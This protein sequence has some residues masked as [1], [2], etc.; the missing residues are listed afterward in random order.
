M[1]FSDYFASVVSNIEITDIIDILLLSIFIYVILKF[2]RETRAA[3]F[4][5][6][7]ALLFILWFLTSIM[8]LYA[9]HSIL[10]LILESG[11][12]AIIILFQPEIRSM[13]EKFGRRGFKT[14]SSIGE[15]GILRDKDN[16][17][18]SMIQAIV[19]ASKNLAI[20]KTGALMV[21]ERDTKL[22][23]IIKTGTEIDAEPT[24]SLILNIFYPNTPL[25]DGAMI[26]RDGR[27]LAAGCFLPLSSAAMEDNLG[28][29]HHAAL[30]VSEI[31]DAVVVIVSEETGII[32][33]AVNGKIT[34]RIT[35]D[36]L[37]DILKDFLIP[38]TEEKRE[39]LKNIFKNKNPLTKRNKIK[40]KKKNKKKTDKK[41]N[42]DI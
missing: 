14:F 32:S 33:I 5:K 6:G 12:I 7:I 13:L 37:S 10:N 35:P 21:I 31:S 9:V 17:N 36:S 41:Q 8:H 25:H 2:V 26:F 42:K 1:N 23:E 11:I 28:T 39:V 40:N 38:E 30:G 15:I 19:S 4:L 18:I 3:Q 27:I 29:R 24:D 16:K 34:R 22:G 20:T